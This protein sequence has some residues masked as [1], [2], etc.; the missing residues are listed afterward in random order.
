MTDPFPFKVVDEESSPPHVV[1][2]YAELEQAEFHIEWLHKA[3]GYVLR[4]KVDRGGYGID[5]PSK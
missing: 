3:G 4:A 2:D 5:G 1:A